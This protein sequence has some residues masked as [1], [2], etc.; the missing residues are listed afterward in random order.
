M[1]KYFVAAALIAA[2]VSMVNAQDYNRV[3][4]SYEVTKRV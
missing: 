3:A 4:L 2:S 1:K